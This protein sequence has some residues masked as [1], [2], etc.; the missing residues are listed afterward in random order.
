MFGFP[1]G[2]RVAAFEANRDWH[3]SNYLSRPQP[4]QSRHRSR[5]CPRRLAKSQSSGVPDAVRSQTSDLAHIYLLADAN[6]MTLRGTMDHQPAD[7]DWRA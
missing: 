7:R 6:G 4:T 5:S 3:G 1:D 2:C